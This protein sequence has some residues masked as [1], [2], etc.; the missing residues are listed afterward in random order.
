MLRHKKRT[1]CSSIRD[2]KRNSVITG[3]VSAMA[4]LDGKQ[5][6]NLRSKIHSLSNKVNPRLT[7]S[8]FKHQSY[9]VEAWYMLHSVASEVEYVCSL[10][11]TLQ[12]LI[13][14]ELSRTF[15]PVKEDDETKSL[16]DVA[17]LNTMV[18]AYC[19]KLE[20]VLSRGTAFAPSRL[21]THLHGKLRLVTYTDTAT[22]TTSLRI[23][24]DVSP[25]AL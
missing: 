24:S 11:R 23:S 6:N 18:T 1:A 2:H 21:L 22:R 13:N 25:L 19:D 10:N 4:A 3:L 7:V 15:R 20:R 8:G 9:L 16:L 12:R 14:E 5:Y 17:I